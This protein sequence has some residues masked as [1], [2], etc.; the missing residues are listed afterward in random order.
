MEGTYTAST[1]H[2]HCLFLFSIQQLVQLRERL[3]VGT[4]VE[5]LRTIES[6]HF[7]LIP[8][9]TVNKNCFSI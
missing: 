6:T 4:D 9:P 5:A 1:V 8:V 2:H 7:A 3:A